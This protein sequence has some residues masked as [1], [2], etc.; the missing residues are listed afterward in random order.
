MLSSVVTAT[1]KFKNPIYMHGHFHFCHLIGNNDVNAMQQPSD[2]TCIWACNNQ[3][4]RP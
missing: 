4:S 1:H 2:V 3:S